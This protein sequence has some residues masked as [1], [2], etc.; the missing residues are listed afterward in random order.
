M[1]QT[2]KYHGMGNPVL[3]PFGKV[4]ARPKVEL[5]LNQT[6]HALDA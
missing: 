6:E 2:E 5:L 3:V 4:A 1:I